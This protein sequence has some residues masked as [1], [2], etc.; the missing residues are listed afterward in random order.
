MILDFC[1]SYNE[2]LREGTEKN[3]AKSMWNLTLK[4]WYK[5]LFTERVYFRINKRDSLFWNQ[6]KPVQNKPFL[7]EI[8]TAYQQL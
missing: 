8:T 7:L 6:L 4:K 1:V 5:H 3:W 2:D